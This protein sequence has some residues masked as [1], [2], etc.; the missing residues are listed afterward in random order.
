[1]NFLSEPHINKIFEKFE[2]Q[3]ILKKRNINNFPRWVLNCYVSNERQKRDIQYHKDINDVDK[4][5]II[6]YF[7]ELKKIKK[8]NI[9]YALNDL[10]SDIIRLIYENV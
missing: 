7:D 3:D 2:K 9:L 1:M 8:I 6:T 10:P 4:Y 5:Y